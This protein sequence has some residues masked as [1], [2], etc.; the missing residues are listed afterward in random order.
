M[1]EQAAKHS[2]TPEPSVPNALL[3]QYL[4]NQ[5]FRKGEEDYQCARVFR[6]A[7]DWLDDNAGGESPFFLWVEAF[8][9]HEPWEPPTEYADRYCPNTTGTDYIIPRL[10]Q[11]PS[12]ADIE[13][14][15]ALYY[16]E[17]SFLDRWIGHLL[18][19]V[20]ELNLWEDTIV[21]V[22][23]DHG[24]QIWDHGQFGKGGGNLRRYNTGIVWQMRIPGQAATRLQPIV[25]AHDV[26]PTLL[27]LLD[28]PYSRCDGQSVMPLV[29]G[30]IDQLREKSL[31][32]WAGPANANAGAFASVRTPQWNYA[33]PTHALGQDV[34]YDL[35]NDPDENVDVK[36]EHPDLV[37]EFQREVEAILGQ[38]LPAKLNEVCDPETFPM[39][40]Y[41]RLL[42]E[43]R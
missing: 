36:A 12:A 5:R 34:L 23:S 11:N 35:A 24:T 32:G 22:L 20:D 13:R 16:G 18:D 31:I 15:K 17:V 37:K 30:E 39:L 42:A 29:R 28:V 6:S 26:M 2:L 7:A 38:P 3:Y 4:L 9:P 14:T 21:V 41:M 8:D 25:Q 10:P 27:E 1:R 43:K 33:T 40:K 19:K